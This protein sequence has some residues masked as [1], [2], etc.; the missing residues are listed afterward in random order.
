MREYKTKM[1]GERQARNFHSKLVAKDRRIKNL[2]H[3][4]EFDKATFEKGLEWFDSG[5]SLD[6]ADISLRENFNFVNGFEK[7][8]RLKDINDS[9]RNLGV[10]WYESGLPLE[11]APANYVNNS[12]FIDGYNNSMNKNKK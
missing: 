11:N 1:L 10:E 9:L 7:A 8:K 3:V 5:L 12:Y 6:D 4:K 2:E